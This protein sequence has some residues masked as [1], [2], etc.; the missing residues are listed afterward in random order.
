MESKKAE[1][2][3]PNGAYCDIKSRAI[4]LP[5]DPQ[6][7]KKFSRASSPKKC[8]KKVKMHG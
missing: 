4:Y 7:E 1:V 2:K 5:Y 6:Y 3:W 8:W